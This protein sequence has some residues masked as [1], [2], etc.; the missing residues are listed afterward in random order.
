[1][2]SENSGFIVNYY[3]TANG[4]K[5][6]REELSDRILNLLDGGGMTCGNI[7]RSLKL[8]K[9]SIYNVAN[10]MIQNHFIVKTKG[11]ENVFV[12]S[13]IKECLLA[14]LL[15]P[16]AEDIEKMFIIKGKITKYAAD[17]K[18]RRS[19]TKRNDFT[20]TTHPLNTI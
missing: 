12:Y 20:Y 19:G 3:T 5:L 16:K 10:W 6:T 15:Y 2:A 9:Q 17:F 11:D 18:N 7:A 13:K 14:D 1:M 8:T 4:T